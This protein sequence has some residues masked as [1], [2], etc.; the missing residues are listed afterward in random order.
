MDSQKSSS[1][2]VTLNKII[3]I[4][5]YGCA[6]NLPKQNTSFLFHGVGQG[7]WSLLLKAMMPMDVSQKSWSPFLVWANTLCKEH[8]TFAT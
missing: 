3:E 7:L 8:P 1:S 2:N 4:Q 6:L 5:L